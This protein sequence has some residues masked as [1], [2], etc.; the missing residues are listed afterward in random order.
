MNLNKIKTNHNTWGLLEMACR[1]FVGHAINVLGVSPTSLTFDVGTSTS[2][3]VC[4]TSLTTIR[5]KS[6]PCGI[7][8]SVED[9]TNTFSISTNRGRSPTNNLHLYE[10]SVLVSSSLS[11]AAQLHFVLV[12][13]RVDRT[14]PSYRGVCCCDMPIDSNFSS[15]SNLNSCLNSSVNWSRTFFCIWDV[16]F[17]SIWDVNSS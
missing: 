15:N 3:Y 1:R 7:V 4:L 17:S 5:K 2:T 11:L 9:P 16:N 13:Q 6:S 8:W 14:T 10:V 12:L